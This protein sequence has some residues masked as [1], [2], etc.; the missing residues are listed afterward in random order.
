M[1]SERPTLERKILERSEMEDGPALAVEVRP[2]YRSR[3]TVSD[4]SSLIQ[5]AGRRFRRWR[6]QET[7]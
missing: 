6:P 1:D 2:V 7:A 3:G 5:E 4:F